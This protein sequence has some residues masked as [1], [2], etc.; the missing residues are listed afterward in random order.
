MG[1]HLALRM[2]G[3]RNFQLGPH[4]QRVCKLPCSTHAVRRDGATMGRHEVHQAEAQRLH[5]GVGCD[6]ER[7]VH[8]RRGFDQDM[9]RQMARRCVQQCLFDQIDVA[10][11]FDLGHHDVAKTMPRLGRDGGHVVEERRVVHRV[12]PHR[13]ASPFICGKRHLDDHGGMFG[14]APHRGTILAV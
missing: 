9:Q 11:R 8:R 5:T 10:H 12:H 14:L 13:H 1:W 3:S 7:A 6:L 4:H 2:A